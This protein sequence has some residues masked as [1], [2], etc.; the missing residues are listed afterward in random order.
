MLC[1]AFKHIPTRYTFVMVYVR[2]VNLDCTIRIPRFLETGIEYSLSMATSK[3]KKSACRLAYVHMK[4]ENA[5][6]HS[7]PSCTYV[8][9]QFRFIYNLTR[10]WQPTPGFCG[11]SSTYRSPTVVAEVERQ[12]E[13]LS[14]MSF[15]WTNRRVWTYQQYSKGQ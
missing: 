12:L 5:G 11:S 14:S 4:S 2:V 7:Q 10:D 8:P 1:H 6:L 9:V 3:H 13:N 15:N